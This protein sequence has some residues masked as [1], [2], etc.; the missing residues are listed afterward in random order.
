[1]DK[2]PISTDLKAI[3]PTKLNPV[4]IV[5]DDGNVLGHYVPQVPSA[6]LEPDGGW[7]SDEEIEEKAKNPG[8]TYTTAEVIAHLRSLG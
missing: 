1:M 5:D 8:V 2:I 6:Y 3:L 7:P 4:V